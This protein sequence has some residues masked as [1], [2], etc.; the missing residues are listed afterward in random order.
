MYTDMLCNVFFITY[1]QCDVEKMNRYTVRFEVL[2]VT[3]MKI[4]VFWDVA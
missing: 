4:T 1:P 3:R 2:M